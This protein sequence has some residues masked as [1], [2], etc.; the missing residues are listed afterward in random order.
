[1]SLGPA[2]MRLQRVVGST[3]LSSGNGNQHVLVL[4]PHFV[5]G[6]LD[7]GSERGL[8][9]ADV[10][11]PAVPGAGDRRTLEQ[12]LGK[13]P[14]LVRANPVDCRDNSINIIKRVDACL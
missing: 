1:M 13:W 7:L 14:A 5:H 12:A 6:L 10:E 11:L 8:T 9:R 4:D 2:E 3:K